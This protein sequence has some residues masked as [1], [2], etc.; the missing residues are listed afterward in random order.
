MHL[1]N[2]VAQHMK[3]EP[4]IAAGKTSIGAVG[5][6]L[7]NAAALISNCTGVSHIAAALRTPSIVISLDGEAYRWA[8]LNKELHRDI[9]WTKNADFNLVLDELKGL[10]QMHKQVNVYQNVI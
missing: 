3:S 7:K 1:V 5:V 9:D 4:I 2:K 6:L 10:L 8:P